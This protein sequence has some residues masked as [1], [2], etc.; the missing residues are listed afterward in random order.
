ME[1][2]LRELKGLNEDLQ[3]KLTSAEQI[4]ESAVQSHCREI[5]EYQEKVAYNVIVAML[6]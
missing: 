4:Y 3:K 2:E 6:G 1:E 5:T